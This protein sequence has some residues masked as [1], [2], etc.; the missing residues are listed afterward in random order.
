MQ[1]SGPAILESADFCVNDSGDQFSQSLKDRLAE[2]TLHFP[3]FGN[4]CALAALREILSKRWK[5]FIRGL[6][7]DP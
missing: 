2:P 4:L 5:L 1:S 3:R 6:K 7:P